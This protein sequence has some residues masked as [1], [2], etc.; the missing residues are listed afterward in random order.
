MTNKKYRYMITFLPLIKEN[1]EKTKEIY[2]AFIQS[3]F[4]DRKKL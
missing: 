1:K 2:I 3:L 4:Q